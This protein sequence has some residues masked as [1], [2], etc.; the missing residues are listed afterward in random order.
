MKYKTQGPKLQYDKKPGTKKATV[1]CSF[2]I[3]RNG[4]TITFVLN[5]FSA[6]QTNV[7]NL[8]TKFCYLGQQ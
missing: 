5:K 7:D 8:C 3:L 6:C 4:S 1:P 2:L